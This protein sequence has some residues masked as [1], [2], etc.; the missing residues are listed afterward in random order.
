MLAFDD[1]YDELDDINAAASADAAASAE[2][3][4]TSAVSQG[5][6][7]A[8]V[9]REAAK[10][11][12]LAKLNDRQ[13]EAVGM[14]RKSALVL[15]G[16]GSGKTSVLTARVAY[17]I[18]DGVD[19]SQI[20]TVTFTNKASQEMKQR[21]GKMLPREASYDM[22]MGTFHSLCSRMLRESYLEAGLPKNFA[23]LDTDGQEALMKTIMRDMGLLP[24]KAERD[25]A[26]AARKAAA[27]D[28]ADPLADVASE[29]DED[30]KRMK[31]SE[32]M[33]WINSKKEFNIKPESIEVGL[34]NQALLITLYEKY[35]DACQEQGLLDFSDLLHR[36]VELLELHESVR[37]RYQSR[38]SAILVDEFQDTNDVQYRWIE[39][40]KSPTAYVMAVGDDDQSIYAFRGANPENMQR[41]VKEMATDGTNP[42]GRVIKL[43]QN[44]RSQ[45]YILDAA[46]SV[47]DHNTN[48][49]GKHLWSGQP[50]GG[51]KIVL[52]EFG[53]SYFEAS[54]VAA[55]IHNLVRNQGANP[56]EIAVLYR[57]NTQSR[58]LEQEL[59]KLSIPV[60]VYGGFRFF[61]RQEVKNVLAYM[62]LA[63]SFERDISFSRVVNFPPRGIGERTIEDLR[64]EAKA[65]N[66]CMM[67]M[68]GIRDQ[69]IQ[70][71]GGAAAR[72]HVQIAQFAELMIDLATMAQ[73][74]TLSELVEAIVEKAG[75]KAFY[76]D[77]VESSSKKK[78][79][80][81][82]EDGEGAE[83]MANIVELISA[84]RQFEQDN[85]HL[86]TA[87]ALLPEYLSFVQLM[88]ST[89][90]ADMDRKSTVSL[91]TVHASKGLE[92][93]HVFLTGAEEG[94]F[95]HARSLEED[96]A[97]GA[98]NSM[99]NDDWLQSLDGQ[100][101]E[102]ELNEGDDVLEDGP[103]IQEER[104][105]MYVAMTRARKDLQITYAATRMMGGEEKAMQRSRFIEEIPAQRI[106]FV[107]DK[108]NANLDESSGRKKSYSLGSEGRSTTQ[109]FK[110]FGGGRNVD[111]AREYGGD[112]YDETRPAYQPAPA[113]AK[114]AAEPESTQEAKQGTLAAP[115]Q[116][117]AA[118]GATGTGNSFLRR[119]KPSSSKTETPAVDQSSSQAVACT[120]MPA[121]KQ[122]ARPSVEPPTEP[123]KPRFLRR[124]GR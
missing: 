104:R 61:E 25:Q 34:E 29:D 114:A 79:K 11:A 71:M 8:S 117:L 55:R 85:P 21:L 73:Q 2:P 91:M 37:A 12:I 118:N 115:A 78:S 14:P 49:L 76:L 124:P 65:K 112:A 58:L 98:G 100:A 99:S 77:G 106:Q 45:P 80:A 122:D 51:D 95:P 4:G 69:D 40:L 22:W 53:S 68:V 110:G 47:I 86:T 90:A 52:T 113:K 6:S 116:P 67:Q 92:F 89:S 87:A 102:A 101:S 24:T 36:T 96:E 32:V 13:A 66:T 30:E 48:R 111:G 15:A 103:G 82:D 44:Y 5:S 109:G 31:P 97:A 84:A 54:T 7:P 46:N 35:Q 26:A 64:Q 74:C 39:L 60:T 20:M 56:S 108:I 81:G 57:T 70:S 62:D 1:I 43:E 16:A 88:T 120:A 10:S 72:K 94:V 75:I 59:N 123:V 18:A 83:R 63:C 28:A 33:N 9:D 27:Q 41:F 119:L 3:L 38:F 107:K 105:L 42:D 19:P 17:L 93:D 50:D 23:I 121:E